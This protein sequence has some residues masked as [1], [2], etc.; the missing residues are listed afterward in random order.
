MVLLIKLYP[1][2]MILR[3]VFDWWTN[4]LVM[5]NATPLTAMS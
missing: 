4:I 2:L 3:E 5:K 1:V